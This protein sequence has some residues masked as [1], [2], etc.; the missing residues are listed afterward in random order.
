MVSS[1]KFSLDLKIL[2]L[3]VLSSFPE[4]RSSP[5]IAKTGDM[6]LLHKSEAATVSS[7]TTP[8]TARTTAFIEVQVPSSLTQG[9]GCTLTANND[10]DAKITLTSEL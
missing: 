7:I 10:G 5:T 6:R 2:L 1:G 8:H 9:Q 4:M 3:G